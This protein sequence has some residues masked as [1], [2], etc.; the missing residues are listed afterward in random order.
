M[1]YEKQCISGFLKTNPFTSIAKVVGFK[2]HSVVGRLCIPC[3]TFLYGV[4]VKCPVTPLKQIDIE[5]EEHYESHTFF[6]GFI[7]QLEAK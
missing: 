1:N 6:E 2:T 4:Y 3:A 5:E 7:E